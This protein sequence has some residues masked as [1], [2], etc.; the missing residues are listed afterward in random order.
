MTIRRSLFALVVCCFAS[1]STILAQQ[2]ATPGQTA[3]A[4]GQT[5]VYGTW[6]LNGAPSNDVNGAWGGGQGMYNVSAANPT[7]TATAT[8]Q[9]RSDGS[10]VVT[11]PDAYNVKGS[12]SGVNTSIFQGA[13]T[14]TFS[15]SGQGGG[16]VWT[17]VGMPGDKSNFANTGVLVT[18]NYSATTTPF[19]NPSNNQSIN[20]T[21]MGAASSVASYN[22]DPSG[23][24]G[25]SSYKVV[26]N[27]QG[28]FSGAPQVTTITT[29]VNG[30]GNT[31]GQNY[32]SQGTTFAFAN[33]GGAGTFAANGPASSTTGS[34]KM[35]GSTTVQITPT[36]V[37]ATSAATSTTTATQ[38]P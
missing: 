11:S 20:G 8:G 28:I 16:A 29:G 27:A 7:G 9:T 31:Q 21:G 10:G 12:L 30:N 18:G 3:T 37:S 6:G 33:S 34:I 13:P 24:S 26:G 1:V 38:K 25:S 14:G 22:M 19:K 35:D 23:L 32:V 17:G 36:T 5:N 4:T 15:A 2:Q